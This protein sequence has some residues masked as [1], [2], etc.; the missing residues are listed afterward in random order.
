[1]ASFIYNK[2]KLKMGN[3]TIN[4]GS[5]TFKMALLSDAYTPSASAHEY[6]SNVSG[7]EISGTGYVAGGASLVSTVWSETSGTVKFDATDSSWT[8]AT[9]TGRYGVIYDDTAA[10]KD[11]VCL[12][13]FGGNKSV[14]NGT[15]TIQYNAAGILTLS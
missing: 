3:G 4:F 5:H 6:Y 11:L 15:F 14:S 2:A 13:D 7:S 10:N 1:M 12:L 8:T 9:F